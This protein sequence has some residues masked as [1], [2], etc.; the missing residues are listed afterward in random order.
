MGRN[1][2]ISERSQKLIHNWP[3]VRQNDFKP[4]DYSVDLNSLIFWLET[5]LTTSSNRSSQEERKI[6]FLLASLRAELLRDLLASLPGDDSHIIPDEVPPSWSD[7]MK[8]ALLLVSG[9]VLAACVGF[10]SVT[11]LI[12]V[13]ALPSVAILL[14][15]LTFSCLSIVVFYSYDLIQISQA[16]GIRLRDTPKLLDVYLLQ[17]S[18]IKSIRRKIDTYLL[19][20][21]CVDELGE[22]ERTLKM[23][24]SCLTDLK[25]A[26]DQFKL[27]LQSTI[28]QVAKAMFTG[29]AGLLAFGSGFFAGQSVAIFVLNVF[30]ASISSTLWPV[31]A[32]S[33]LVGLASF[34]LYWFVQ[35]VE[36]KKIISGWFG[37]DEGKVDELCCQ[38]KLAKEEKKL[39]ILKDKV[40]AT[41]RLSN[42]QNKL[43]GSEGEMGQEGAIQTGLT[44]PECLT[45]AHRSIRFFHATLDGVDGHYSDALNMTCKI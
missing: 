34:S 10:D 5:E 41:A 18:E 26:S 8:F 27:A 45:K 31:I 19:A 11:T 38:N 28:M 4:G 25:K 43:C 44:K 35:R 2:K 6:E 9:T 32:F 24:Q 16:L 13:L 40:S 29:V 7:K 37:L 42:P 15:G 33:V 20:N 23:L 17:M 14:V 22:L 36:L 3:K 30:F 21:L 1:V 12:G 39:S